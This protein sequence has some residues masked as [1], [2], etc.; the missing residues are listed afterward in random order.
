MDRSTTS[1]D[2]ILLEHRVNERVKQDKIPIKFR[3]SP[4]TCLR[5]TERFSSMTIWYTRPESSNTLPTHTLKLEQRFLFAISPIPLYASSFVI[6]DCERRIRSSVLSACDYRRSSR[7]LVASP[8]HM[9]LSK[10]PDLESTY[11][12]WAL[13]IAFAA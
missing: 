6:V 1:K 7:R 2:K 9:L 13:H 4:I 3:N 5:A 11:T 8:R 12:P 10:A